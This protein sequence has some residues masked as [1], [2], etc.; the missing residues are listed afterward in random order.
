MRALAETVDGQMQTFAANDGRYNREHFFGQDPSLA[1][2][3]EGM[4]DE[5]IDRLRRGGHDMA[6]VYAAYAAAMASEGKPTVI[7]AHTMKGYGMGSAGQGRMNTHS[8]KKFEDT[9]ILQF[10]DRF[11]LPLSD[12]Q[13]LRLDFYR[14]P[15]DSAELRYLR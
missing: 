9:D 6:K 11:A 4:T 10:R 8:N 5:D 15:A 14:P 3:V 1:R 7:L 12:E 13:A 2:L